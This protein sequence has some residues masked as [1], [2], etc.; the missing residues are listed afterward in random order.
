MA[1]GIVGGLTGA[2]LELPALPAAKGKR[3]VDSARSGS[4][5]FAARSELPQRQPLRA[6]VVKLVDTP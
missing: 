3:Q 5:S 1:R 6:E 2:L 4:V